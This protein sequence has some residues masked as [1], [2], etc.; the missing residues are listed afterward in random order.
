MKARIIKEFRFEAAHWLP[1]V[2][3][4]H[5]CSHIHGHSYR[6]EIALKGDVG[7]AGWLVDFADIAKAWEPISA[8][9]DH[10]VINEVVNNPTSEM[11]ARWIWDELLGALPMLD[12]VTVWET[13]DARCEYEGDYG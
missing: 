9:L 11:L 3:P 2:A 1:N 5:H 8:K 7:Q 6:V 13:A 12:R 10:A 4:A